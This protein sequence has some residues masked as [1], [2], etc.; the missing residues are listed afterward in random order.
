VFYIHG[1][2]ILSK[3]SRK[4]RTTIKLKYKIGQ[5]I[6]YALERLY[7]IFGNITIRNGRKILLAMDS[8]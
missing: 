3:G 7:G 8:I 1:I 6:I 2:S 4:Y 5:G